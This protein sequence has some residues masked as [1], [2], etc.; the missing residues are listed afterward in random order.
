MKKLLLLVGLALFASVPAK[1]AVVGSLGIDPTSATGNFSNTVGGATFTDF[2]TFQLIGGPQFVT[3]AS[4]T[5]VFP[6]GSGSTDFIK[7]FTGEVFQ[8]LGATPNPGT[9]TL[10]LGPATAMACAVAPTQCQVL[11]GSALLNPGNFY[12]DISGI[13]GGTSGYG[14]NLAV[15]AVPLPATAQLFIGGLLL[16]GALVF[17]G[18]RKPNAS[19]L[20]A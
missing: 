16:F 13:G 18:K 5:N 10:V 2:Y 6:G 7:N 15:S 8:Q 17:F 19:V 11:S 3:L 1:A 9:D 14:G 12:L 4:A 20:A